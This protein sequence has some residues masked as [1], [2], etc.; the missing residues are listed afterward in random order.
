MID[1]QRD[2]VPDC[3]PA[4]PTLLQRIGRKLAQR[5]AWR[6]SRSRHPRLTLVSQY[7]PPDFAA[8]GQLLDDL[9]VR[10]AAEGLQV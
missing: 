8:T 2:S 6:A 5:F 4:P 1:L 3:A 10:L 9:T 7:F